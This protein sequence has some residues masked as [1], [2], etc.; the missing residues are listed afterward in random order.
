MLDGFLVDRVK[1]ALSKREPFKSAFLDLFNE[2]FDYL[3]EGEDVAV[4]VNHN[5][6]VWAFSK[7]RLI[8]RG[9]CAR[10]HI[11][12]L[13]LPSL[14]MAVVFLRDF[15][16]EGTRSREVKAHTL[17]SSAQLLIMRQIEGAALLEVSTVGRH[18][19]LPLAAS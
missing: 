7:G 3:I 10:L 1:T 9:N 12:L 17:L 2:G 6:F 11:I 8:L 18:V 16:V 13:F 19:V 5:P 4:A 14:V 15:I